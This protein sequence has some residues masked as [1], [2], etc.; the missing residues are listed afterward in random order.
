ME[1]SDNRNE[2]Q[3]M[4][5]ISQFDARENAAIG[6][7]AYDCGAGTFS[8]MTGTPAKN[9]YY[10]RSI[11]NSTDGDI[12]VVFK[13]FGDTTSYTARVPTGQWY[14]SFGNIQ[15][16]VASGTTSATV[17]LAYSNRGKVDATGRYENTEGRRPIRPY[18]ADERGRKNRRCEFPHGEL[19][20]SRP[21]EYR[22]RG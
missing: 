10:C 5:M 19:N 18:G 13:V 2:R 20:E 4:Q 11:Y 12:V 22:C 8:G 7:G 3:S 1:P 9:K 6:I 16:I 15:T 14:H 17:T 21:L